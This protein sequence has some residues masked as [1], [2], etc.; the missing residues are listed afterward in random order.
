MKFRANG[1]YIYLAMNDKELEGL[2]QIYKDSVEKWVRA[3]RAEEAVAT[4]DHSI[5]AWDIWEKAGF[6]EEDARQYAL[7]AKKKYE[8]GLRELH[9]GIRT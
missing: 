8:S 4:S 3:I 9:Y 5:H 2:R 1:E 7:T 6:D